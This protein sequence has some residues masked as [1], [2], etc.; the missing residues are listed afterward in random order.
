MV[1]EPISDLPSPEDSVAF[2]TLLGD[3]VNKVPRDL[4]EISGNQNQFRSDVKLY[5]RVTPPPVILATGSTDINIPYYPITNPQTVSTIATQDDM[6]KD[7]VGNQQI[8]GPPYS[9]VY[10]EDSNPYLARLAQGNN[11]GNPI[12]SLQAADY[13]DPY[14]ILLGV[15]ETNPRVSL[16]DIYYETSTT[17]LV[18]DL[19]AVA[20]QD[21]IS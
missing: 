5:G 2:I 7:D 14:R 16:L 3:N 20:G 1:A 19:N 8:V 21:E 10:E 11:P 17:G 6:F 12:G 4:N 18:E 13:K 9:T 15:F